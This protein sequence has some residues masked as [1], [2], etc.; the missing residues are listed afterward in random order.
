[1][2]APSV[3]LTTALHIFTHQLPSCNLKTSMHHSLLHAYSFLL[4][5]VI[6]L[7]QSFKSKEYVT[8]LFAWRHYYWFLTDNGIDYLR[9]Y[10]NLPSEIVPATL[11]KSTRYTCLHSSMQ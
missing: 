11:K 2:L 6:K 4:V 8:E 7:M 5:Q 1:M 10:L 9:T 3:R